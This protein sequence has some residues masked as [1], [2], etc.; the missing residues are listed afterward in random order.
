MSKYSS[1][2]GAGPAAEDLSQPEPAPVTSHYTLLFV[3][4]EPGILRALTR[5]FED[6]NYHVLTASDGE[7]AM[8]VLEQN[9][10]HLV[11]SDFMMPRMNGAQFLSLAK[12]QY[13]DMIRIML[14]GHADTRAVMGAINEGAVYKFILKPWH[15]D[16]LRITVAVAL[17]QYELKKRNKQLE[18]DNKRKQK[19]IKTMSKLA[20]TNR[21]Q[22]AIMLHKRHLL[23]DRQLQEIYKIQG[24]LKAPIIKVIVERG[25]VEESRIHKILRDELLLQEIDL[26]EC[27]V[28]QDALDFL[29][30]SFCNRHFVL[31]LR[32]NG[33]RMT[34]VTADPMDEGLITDLQFITGMQIEPVMADMQAILDKIREAYHDSTDFS[35]LEA[36]VSQEDPFESVEIVIED[37]D[38]ISIEELLKSTEEPPAVRIVNAIIIEA[39]R[40]GVSDIHIHP[41]S[42]HVAVR[43]R[44]DGIL[45]DKIHVPLN[46][47]RA[48]VSRIKVMAELDISERRRPQDGRITVKTP[49]RMVDLR[50]ST[51][52][53]INGEKVVLRILDKHGAIKRLDEQGFSPQ[54]LTKVRT[55]IQQPQ[56]MILVTG[57]T[58]SGK[59]TT[60]YT[61]LQ[62]NATTEK[63]YVTIEDPVE[64]YMDLAG[65]VSVRGKLNLDFSAI[66]RAILRQ[67]PDVILLGEIRDLETAQVAFHAAM[68]GHL[69]Y[70]TLHTNSA[71]A[72]VSRLVD[73]GLKP[74]VVSAGLTGVIAQR[75]LRRICNHCKQGVVPDPQVLQ[76][77]GGEFETLPGANCGT[78]CDRCNGTGYSGRVPIYEVLVV[79]DAMRE[80]IYGLEGGGG[81]GQLRTAAG[82][83]GDLYDSALQ[84]IRDGLTTV[85]EVMRVLG[86]RC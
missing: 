83:H 76:S 78:G 35:D 68:T 21:S 63:N 77:L 27:K 71:L 56:G 65:Q 19:Q 79:D 73:I 30:P 9:E 29:T 34:M 74:F 20:V 64:F 58:G 54:E 23:T 44:I 50:I 36:V 1:L 2:F 57:P 69:V 60:L 53:T 39:V 85:D 25:W 37:D 48:I 38:D 67:D 49:L 3:D 10:V 45:Q 43:Y 26:K 52:P 31:P 41:R 32:I 82:Q 81:Q 24:G 59:T 61:L 75:L 51:L 40:L 70:S 11:I 12:K 13:P 16:D 6:E 80:A 84:R 33:N 72:T 86:P 62:H 4:D 5:V 8:K 14:T 46:Y 15:D 66:L 28:E 55:M 17:E 47:L 7:Q 22:I 42:K 18:D